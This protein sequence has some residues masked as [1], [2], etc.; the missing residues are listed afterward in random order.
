MAAELKREI[1]ELIEN[2]DTVKLL[3]TLDEKGQPH[4]VAKNSIRVLEDGNIVYLELLESSKSYKNF[5]RSLWYNQK[6]TLSIVGDKGISYQVRGN[7][8]KIII[9]GPVFEKYYNSVRERLGDVD[10]AAVCVIK[11]VEVI[12]E[13]FF[14]RFAE[15]ENKQP[16]F[17]HLDRLVK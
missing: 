10:L 1:I 2:N 14:T 16:I 7:P 3:V 4:A 17:K 5:T 15:Q 6:V 13:S 11:P 12:N 8:E 9:S